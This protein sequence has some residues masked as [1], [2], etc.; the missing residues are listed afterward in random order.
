MQL[1]KLGNYLW[2]KKIEDKLVVMMDIL[3]PS[4][5]FGKRT[6]QDKD[7]IGIL[8]YKI[9]RKSIWLFLIDFHFL[10]LSSLPLNRF[11]LDSLIEGMH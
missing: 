7:V 6:P 3:G 1:R 2:D 8:I 9:S 10:L 5:Y 11:L 4:C